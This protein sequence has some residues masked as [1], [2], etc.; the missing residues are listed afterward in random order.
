MSDVDVVEIAIAVVEFDDKFLI[1]ERPEGAPLA[2][3]WE[4]PGGK[5]EPGETP[6]ETAA[7]E[8]REETGLEVTI[9]EEYPEVI[10]EYEHGKLRL[11]FF[12]AWPSEFS[13][14]TNERFQ[15]ALREQ[16]ADYEFPDANASLLALLRPTKDTI[17]WDLKSL[18]GPSQALVV[19]LFAGLLMTSNDGGGIG[20]SVTIATVGFVLLGMSVVRYSIVRDSQFSLQQIFFDLTALCVTCVF[21]RVIGWPVFLI[22]VPLI[23]LRRL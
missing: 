5:V 21:A 15:W 12:K 23:L 10:H 3:Y 4:F 11:H 1:G 17:T 20:L 7:R 13:L 2:G 14:P 6:R 18:L 16:L 8:C 9:G 22:W 19:L